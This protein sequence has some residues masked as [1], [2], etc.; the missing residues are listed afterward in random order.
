[1]TISHHLRRPWITGLGGCLAGI[2]LWFAPPTM[3]A[4]GRGVTLDLL[5][6]GL[7]LI[8]EAVASGEARWDSWRASQER[9]LVQ[10]RDAAR[11]EA[12]RLAER[13]QRLIA[14]QLVVAEALPRTNSGVTTGSPPLFLPA[15]VEARVMGETL[16]RDWRSGA[17]LDRGWQGGVRESALVLQRR[18][19]LVD[20]GADDQLSTEDPLVIGSTV[21]G[22]IEVVGRWTSTFLPVTDP[23]FR[24]AVQLV[25]LAESGPA[26]GAAGILHGTGTAC[27]IEGLPLDASVRVGDIVYSAGR[28]GFLGDPLYYGE[29]T[30]A[31][32]EPNDREWQI[33]VTPGAQDRT[34][35]HVH[36]LRAA[37]NPQRLMGN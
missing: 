27:R 9:Q 4:R 33:T 6:P 35:T 22:K 11:D 30:A 5:R 29:V 21:V 16:S 8:D 7:R 14:R 24:A 19:P 31:T 26:W 10:E 17:L 1:M 13:W 23:D 32:L 37:L 20:L 28:D 18:R 2:V 3:V 36:V 12:A 25:R 15:L 34:L